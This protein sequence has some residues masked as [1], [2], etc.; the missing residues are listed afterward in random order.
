MESNIVDTDRKSWKNWQNMQGFRV[1][2]LTNWIHPTQMIADMLTIKEHLGKLK[3][4]K[5][6]YMGDARYNMGNS[7]MVTCA[8]LG[9]HFRCL[10]QSKIL[11]GQEACGLFVWTWHRPT[12]T[13]ITGAGVTGGNES[14]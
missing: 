3:G 8:K 6:V 14:F 5:F 13:T 2:G 10:H 7:L 4:V 12:G 9:M 11:S 1:D